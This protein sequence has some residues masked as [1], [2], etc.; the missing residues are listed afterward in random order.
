[1]IAYFPLTRHGPHRKRRL[2]QFLFVAG[3]YLPGRCLATIGDTQ[4]DPQTLLWYHTDRIENDA[5]NNSIVACVFVAAVKFFTKPL[6]SNIYMTH[7]LMGGIFKYTVQMGSGVMIYTPSFIKI[8]LGIEKLVGIGD[9]QTLR[10]R[11]DLI[12]LLLFF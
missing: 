1:V 4:T 6:P 7:R 5:Y 10:P 3:T 2:Q 12:S 8:G 11:G 9:S